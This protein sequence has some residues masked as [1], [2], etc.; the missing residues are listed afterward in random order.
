[1]IVIKK[2]L[3][4]VKFWGRLVR[5]GRGAWA[6]LTCEYGPHLT[7]N[8]E[9]LPKFYIPAYNFLCYQDF[10]LIPSSGKNTS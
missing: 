9:E 2:L 7:P 5:I 10:T 1:M 6:L 3:G 8:Y 4:K